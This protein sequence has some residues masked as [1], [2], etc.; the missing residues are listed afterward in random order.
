[1]GEH[2]RDDNKPQRGQMF[3]RYGALVCVVIGLMIGVI[4]RASYVYLAEGD[5]WIKLGLESKVSEVPIDAQRGD[6]LSHNGK[7]LASS[8]PMYYLQIDFKAGGFSADTLKKH[9]PELAKALSKKIK[10]KSPR[11][12]EIHILNGLRQNSRQFTL[13]RQRVSFIDLQEIKKFPYL[14]LSK[15]K[16]GFYW[17]EMLQRQ[18]PFGSLASRTIGDV[19]A[20]KDKG[21]KNGL[22]LEFDSLLR[23][24]P[25]KGLMKRVRSYRVV[26]PFLEP[27][28]GL[29]ITTTIDVRVQDI[30]ER[31]LVDQLKKLDAEMGLVVLMDVKSGEV[32]AISNM[33]RISTGVYGETK[34]HAVSDLLEPGSTFKVAS[35]M[36]AL[37]DDAISVS[38]SVF[39]ENGAWKVYGKVMK[40]HNY[41]KGGYG[42]L[43]VP[44]IIHN[45]SNIGIAKIIDGHY[46]SNP[47]KFIQGLEKIGLTK[48][49]NMPIPGSTAPR[50]KHPS[51]SSWSKLTLPW[52]SMGYESQ[53]PPIYTLAFFN[54]I[55]NDGKMISPRFV[56]SISDKGSKVKEFKSEVI[57]SSICSS[58]TLKEIRKMLEGV[59]SE[60]T[61]QVAKSS[62]INIA[63]KTGTAQVSQGSGGYNR[64]RHRVSFAGYFPAEKPQYSGIVVI[65]NPNHGYASGG[66]MAGTVI[67]Q[68][69][70]EVYARSFK[71]D[72]R[73]LEPDST[74]VLIPQIKGGL[75]DAVEEVTSELNLKSSSSTVDSKTQWVKVSSGEEELEIIA[76]DYSDEI[77]PSVNG[78]GLKDALHM[79]EDRGLR[80][81]V[82]G[83]GRVYQQSIQAGSRFRKGS[84]IHIKLR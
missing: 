72:L 71:T 66:A 62:Y 81:A 79:L 38:D 67:K 78:M 21:G 80:V 73:E 65:L 22:E 51:N 26:E 83:S 46:K 57:N 63:G 7:V 34:N 29:D 70:E 39:C 59:I 45:S 48:E 2:N 4:V 6:I 64:S 41:N 5:E 53:I 33:G 56:K 52:M 61:A 43:T 9:L 36:V 35:M 19:Y 30:A 49:F 24:K 50:I 47:E 8:M 25:G 10:D 40:D 12:Y 13:S 77:V 18:K 74:I 32:R 84:S 68:I 69:A 1:M 58:R 11:E 15:N 14:K 23:G 28:H 27:V 16:S 54:A 3:L 37:E 55:A 60:G 76:L 17:K 44:E 82:S 75:L 42:W 20:D 31:V